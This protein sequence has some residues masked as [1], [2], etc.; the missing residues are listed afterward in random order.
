MVCQGGLFVLHAERDR[1]TVLDPASGLGLVA[2]R[3]EGWYR[4]SG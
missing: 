4:W 3:I 1:G 2:L